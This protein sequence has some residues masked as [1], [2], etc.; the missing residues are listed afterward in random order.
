MDSNSTGHLM[1]IE[2]RKTTRDL[3]LIIHGYTLLS[4]T[5]NG[6]DRWIGLQETDLSTKNGKIREEQGDFNE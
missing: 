2:I 3:D 6:V 5:L 4:L 1:K